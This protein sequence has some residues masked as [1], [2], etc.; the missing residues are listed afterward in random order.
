MSGY[1]HLA[2]RNRSIEQKAKFDQNFDLSMN[3][4]T[5]KGSCLVRFWID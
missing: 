3:F 4:Y 1:F 2:K 5:D